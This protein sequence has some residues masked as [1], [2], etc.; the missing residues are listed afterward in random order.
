MRIHENPEEKDFDPNMFG[1]T[2]N[3]KQIIRKK[4]LQFFE[5][6]CLFSY[7]TS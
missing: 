6:V 1:P 4:L 3:R 2:T 7:I 5:M